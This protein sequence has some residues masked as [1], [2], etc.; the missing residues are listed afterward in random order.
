MA[1]AQ[2]RAAA[3][4]ERHVVLMA[5]LREMGAVQAARQLLRHGEGEI[6]LPAAVV[7]VVIVKMDG[8]VMSRV[9]HPV[10]LAAVP[11]VSLHGPGREIDGG[12]VPAVWRDIHRH[13]WL[14]CRD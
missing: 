3:H 11:G 14:E 4:H 12:A 6:A 9:V 7:E 8:T 10:V 2:C 1:P 13:A 5:V